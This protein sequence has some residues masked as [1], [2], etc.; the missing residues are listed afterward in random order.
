MREVFQGE[1]CPKKRGVLM[2]KFRKGRGARR[3][4]VLMRE[5]CLGVNGRCPNQRGVLR[6]EVSEGERCPKGRG[7]LRGE[8]S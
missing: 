3:G 2:K 6:G 5:V 8:V 7:V 4:G 1:R